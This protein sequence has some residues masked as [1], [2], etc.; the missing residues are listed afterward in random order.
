M[1]DQARRE[2]EGRARDTGECRPGCLLDVC[3]I[4]CVRLRLFLLC[5]TGEACWLGAYL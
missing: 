1:A 5:K 3:C 2:A 4:P